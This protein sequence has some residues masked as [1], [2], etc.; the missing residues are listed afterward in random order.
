MNDMGNNEKL[1]ENKTNKTTTKEERLGDTM[2]TVENV[3]YDVVS[4][5]QKIKEYISDFKKLPPDDAQKQA[6]MN[7]MNSGIIDSDGKLTGYYKK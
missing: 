4:Y 1:K 3:N 2:P 5:I 6:K 7:L